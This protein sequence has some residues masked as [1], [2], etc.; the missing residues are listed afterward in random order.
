MQRRVDFGRPAI[1]TSDVAPVADDARC[2]RVGPSRLAWAREQPLDLPP[3]T[4][5][6]DLS[7][8]IGQNA[9]LLTQVG[10]T[11]RSL[12]GIRRLSALPAPEPILVG[13]CTVEDGLELR[14]I[15]P[16]TGRHRGRTSESSLGPGAIRLDG[17]PSTAHT[18]LPW[19]VARSLARIT[20]GDRGAID[21]AAAL[22]LLFERRRLLEGVGCTVI[23]DQ[24][25]DRL[26]AT[27]QLSD[28]DPVPMLWWASMDQRG[29]LHPKIDA[30]VKVPPRLLPNAEPLEHIC[31]RADVLRQPGGGF[32][33][34]LR[35]I[36]LNEPLA[37]TRPI[38]PGTIGLGIHGG[39]RFAVL[40]DD[41][42]IE[43]GE[44]AC[45][46]LAIASESAPRKFAALASVF[47]ELRRL[48]L[49]VTREAQ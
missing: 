35:A 42:G 2:I 47:D 7:A 46:P 41:R 8:A 27:V 39:K 12:A 5:L 6:P 22:Q 24:H 25:D 36:D 1:V 26:R 37:I 43:A 15:A 44:R 17:P 33:L 28:D 10:P 14:C 31:A 13:E 32:A 23:L 49:V 48:P 45:V 40:A 9:G 30:V 19:T 4:T 34:S 3:T 29:V 20:V 38:R 21:D 16:P 18:R 11:S